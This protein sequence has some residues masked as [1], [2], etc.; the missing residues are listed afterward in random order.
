MSRES[1]S[2]LA[3]ELL[4]APEVQAV[5]VE[6]RTATIWSDAAFLGSEPDAKAH[7]NLFLRLTLAFF[8][9]DPMG[10]NFIDNSEEYVP[11]VRT[12]LPRLPGA[13]S[14]ADVQRIL[15][16]EFEKWFGKAG[17][18][19]TY[20]TLALETWRAWREESG[21]EAPDPS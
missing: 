11:E 8:V 9:F 2:H 5:E 4:S 18:M 1:A 16:E 13:C 6:E 12:V 15:H 19:E 14:A 7:R 17:P 3:T 21:T 10:I 20:E